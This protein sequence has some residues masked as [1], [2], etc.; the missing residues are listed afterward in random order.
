[1]SQNEEA[2]NQQQ[3]IES[4]EQVYYTPTSQKRLNFDDSGPME[5]EEYEDD[6]H[7]LLTRSNAF[8]GRTRHPEK[9]PMHGFGVQSQALIGDDEEEDDSMSEDA[10][11][12]AWFFRKIHPEVDKYSQI[13]WCRTYA[14]MLAAQMPKNRPTTYKKR[15]TNEK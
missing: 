15:K 5:D 4:E 1:M 11:D 2:Q 9:E 10:G 12:L 3:V 14:N 8:V 6:E 7:Q 13:A